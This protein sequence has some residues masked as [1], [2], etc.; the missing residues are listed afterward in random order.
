MLADVQ[1]AVGGIPRQNRWEWFDMVGERRFSEAR[2]T[3]S[4]LLDS[5]ETGVGLVIGMGT[6]LLRL[7]IVAHG[8]ERALENALPSYQRW[9]AS[10]RARQ[11]GKWRAA[12]LDGALE[13]LLRADRLLKS[14]NLGDRAILEELI[15]R[16][17]AH[18]YTN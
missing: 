11:A 14:T 15:L 16:F 2:A 9:L 8:G 10:R 13:D 4:T 7:G 18:A 17:Q 5:G 1:A 3:L 12:D 6:H